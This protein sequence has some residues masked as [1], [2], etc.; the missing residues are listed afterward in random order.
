MPTWAGGFVRNAAT[1]REGVHM[2]ATA[3]VTL[4]LPDSFLLVNCKN[5]SDSMDS[6]MILIY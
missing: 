3:Y 5:C 1:G 2:T 6:S 4:R